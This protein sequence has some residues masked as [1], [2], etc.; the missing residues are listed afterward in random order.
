VGTPVRLAVLG[1]GTIVRTE[2]LPAIIP[3]PQIQVS[4]LVDADSD[5]ASALARNFRLNCKVASDYRS[6]LPDIDAVLNA[7]PN[8]LHAPVTLDALRAGKHVLCEKPLAITSSDARACAAAAAEKNLIVAVGMNR[9]FYDNHTLLK[10]ILDEGAL[11]TLQDYDWHVGNPFDWNAA[12][13]FYFSKAQA[14]GGALLDY[15]VHLLDHLFDWF[16]PVKN[17][18]YEDDDW[19]GGIE[20]NCHLALEHL[21]PYG[22]VT[23]H[24]RLSRTHNT[25]NRLLVGGS[26][27]HAELPADNPQVVILHRKINGRM[28]RDTVA[29]AGEG[30]SKPSTFYFQID[31]FV[32]SIEGLEQP[33]V[34]G[35]Q[36]AAVLELIEN[37]YA[38]RTRL[39]EP[40]SEIDAP[41]I[42]PSGVP[43]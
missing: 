35:I 40:W 10:A 27:A 20:A 21:G 34:D 2:H 11:G 24:V 41:E 22:A 19:G 38:R 8:H 18:Q 6:V 30:K 17:F 13:N 9:R 14:G 23:G 31:N 1:C 33:R 28:V 32:R 3:H 12:S 16:G 43:R 36:A 4:A 25:P 15:G 29:L 42:A 37:C 7:L 26:E 39:P 5:R